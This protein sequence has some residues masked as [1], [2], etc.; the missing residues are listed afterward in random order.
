MQACSPAGLL[1][2]LWKKH[3]GISSNKGVGLTLLQRKER[4][5]M[6]DVYRAGTSGPTRKSAGR[7]HGR[8]RRRAVIVAM[9]FLSGLG[10]LGLT[11]TWATSSPIAPRQ[12]SSLF[13]LPAGWDGL[14]RQRMGDASSP[15]S[16][17]T[18]VNCKM[19]RSPARAMTANRLE[20]ERRA[21]LPQSAGPFPAETRHIRCSDVD[22]NGRG[23]AGAAG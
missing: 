7:P 11:V 21:A 12:G 9:L 17:T 23:Q 8:D 4:G 2:V 22:R 5:A 19:S 13:S 16:I 18:P 15:S 20:R 1:P 10:A 6:K 3:R 14:S